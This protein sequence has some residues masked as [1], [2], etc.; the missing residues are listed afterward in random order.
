M[1]HAKP[2]V[3]AGLLMVMY[4]VASSSVDGSWFDDRIRVSRGTFSLRKT[5]RHV[6]ARTGDSRESSPASATA[7]EA[8]PASS[9]RPMTKGLSYAK[10]EKCRA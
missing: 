4:C 7:S 6:G 10:I 5:S 1:W 8:M 2:N 9:V 3:P